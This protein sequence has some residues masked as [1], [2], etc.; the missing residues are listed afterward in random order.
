MSIFKEPPRLSEQG[1]ET[2][3]FLRDALIKARAKKDSD[4]QVQRIAE[5][6]SPIMG[7]KVPISIATQTNL[8][9][10]AS[11]ISLVGKILGGALCLGILT[12]IFY[13]S[14]R[15]SRPKKP[16]QIETRSEINRV[17]PA[18]PLPEIVDAKPTRQTAEIEQPRP[19][20]LAKSRIKARH[21]IDKRLAPT[22]TAEPSPTLDP[23]S[24]LALLK[25]AQ[26]L[27]DRK[28][29][30][31]LELTEEHLRLYPNGVFGQEREML[32]IEA[33]SKLGKKELARER[34]KRFVQR[35]PDS[36]HSRRIDNLL[37][38]RR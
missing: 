33:L 22:E 10:N 35:Y 17:E 1:S 14:T 15:E 13:S 11:G 30:Q 34:G 6:L 32:A 26:Q 31:T 19:T 5:R 29:Q 24:E 18:P 3:A 12:M 21:P 4:A 27:L 7:S 23:A 36:A 38:Q 8:S 37:E 20:V 16:A 2:S 25:S 28:P 9:A